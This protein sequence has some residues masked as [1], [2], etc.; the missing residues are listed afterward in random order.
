[1]NVDKILVEVKLVDIILVD[2]KTQ[3][4]K[5]EIKIVR[6]ICDSNE[7]YLDSVKVIKILK[8][9]NCRNITELRGFLEIY[10]YYRI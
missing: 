5:Q 10:R 3:W 2:K 6:F 1:M 9:P 7:R 4:Y 8:W